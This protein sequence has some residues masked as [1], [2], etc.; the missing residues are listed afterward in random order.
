MENKEMSFMYTIVRWALLSA[1]LALPVPGYSQENNTIYITHDGTSELEVLY[2]RAASNAT[3]AAV[4]GLLGAAVQ[5]GIESN[6]DSA[7][8]SEI[9]PFLPADIWQKTFYST[10]TEKLESKG[11]EVKYVDG[12]SLGELREGI[13]VQ[14]R[15]DI[16]GLK[17]V[18]TSTMQ[19]SAFAQFQAS[20]TDA[21]STRKQRRERSEHY[22]LTHKAQRPFVSFASDGALVLADVEKI[23][24]KSAKRL[25]NKIIYR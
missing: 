3:G 6:Q 9:E 23:I 4:A 11:Y 10:L 12:K 24:A 7:K 19:V 16:H 21:P 18:N 25:A 20:I 13:L 1:L 15:H 22:Y 14:I 17:A 5:A 2:E 8:K